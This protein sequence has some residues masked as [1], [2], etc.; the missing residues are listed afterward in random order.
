M[1]DRLIDD[2]L[3]K[4]FHTVMVRRISPPAD[5]N[6]HQRPAKGV[7][8]SKGPPFGRPCEGQLML[9]DV[10]SGSSRSFRGDV[11]IV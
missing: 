4:N 8:V 9:A 10:G 6:S 2:V 5:Q 3:N 7:L 11:L 1:A